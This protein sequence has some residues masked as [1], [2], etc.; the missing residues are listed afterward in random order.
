MPSTTLQPFY[1][2]S[3]TRSSLDKKQLE[4]RGEGD[5]LWGANWGT[6]SPLKEINRLYPFHRTGQPFL[7]LHEQHLNASSIHRK[8]THH[9]CQCQRRCSGGRRGEFTARCDALRLRPSL[10]NKKQIQ[11]VL[12]PFNFFFHPQVVIRFFLPPFYAPPSPRQ[13]RAVVLTV[14]AECLTALLAACRASAAVPG[15]SRFLVNLRLDSAAISSSERSPRQPAPPVQLLLLLLASR[16]SDRAPRSLSPAARAHAHTYAP[17]LRGRT[18]ARRR[19][20]SKWAGN[21]RL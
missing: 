1:G 3:F 12:F 11:P 16:N 20:L 19:G 15:F 18:R 21:I 9:E 5:L 14:T 2:E 7:L 6:Y 17:V 8:Q 4:P 13:T 10:K